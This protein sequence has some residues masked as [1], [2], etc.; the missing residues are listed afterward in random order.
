M[1]SV[2]TEDGAL[3]TGLLYV[4]LGAG[5]VAVG[6]GADGAVALVL[7]VSEPPVSEDVGAA[8]DVSSSSVPAVVLVEDEGAA[9]L[10]PLVEVPPD[11]LVDVPPDVSDVDPLP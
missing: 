1:P 2:N 9:E 7:P 8:A 11:V 5:D 6:A 3:V 10:V 4:V